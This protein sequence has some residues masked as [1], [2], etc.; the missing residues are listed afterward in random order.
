ML[1]IVCLNAVWI[2]TI[3]RCFCDTPTATFAVGFGVCELWLCR[4]S[5]EFEGIAVAFVLDFGMLLMLN[6]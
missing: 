6:A 1:R 3:R 4:R 2:L 5:T